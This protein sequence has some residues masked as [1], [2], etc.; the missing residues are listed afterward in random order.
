MNP[1]L[2]FLF[3]LFLTLQTSDRGLSRNVYT[4]KDLSEEI[5]PKPLA[6][7]P[8]GLYSSLM[9]NISVH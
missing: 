4:S 9:G 2:D 6:E 7:T 5:L 1:C 3:L 8:C